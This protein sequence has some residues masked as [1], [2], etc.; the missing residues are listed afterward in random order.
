METLT[1]GILFSESKSFEE[2]L[3]EYYGL[4]CEDM[5]GDLRCRFPYRDVPGNDF[6]LTVDEV[7]SLFYKLVIVNFHHSFNFYMYGM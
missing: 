4:E 7:S 5:I 3:D 1:I 2:Y 6:G